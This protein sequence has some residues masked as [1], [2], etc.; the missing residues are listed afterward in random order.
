[1]KPP[2]TVTEL[3]GTIMELLETITHLLGS[4]NDLLGT[5]MGSEMEFTVLASL[6]GIP[7]LKKYNRQI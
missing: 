3:A 6:I 2:T 1:M 5:I 7:E 4:V